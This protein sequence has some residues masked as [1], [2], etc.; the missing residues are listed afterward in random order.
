[1]RWSIVSCEELPP[2]RDVLLLRYLVQREDSERR[3]VF[4][5]LSGTVAATSPDTLPSP[6]DEVVRTP[7]SERDRGRSR[8]DRAYEQVRTRPPGI[9]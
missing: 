1:M 6:L 8:P 4:V 7:G 2:L 9:A 5:E 3:E